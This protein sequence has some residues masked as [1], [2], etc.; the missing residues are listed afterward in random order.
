MSMKKQC[1]LI[2][3]IGEEGSPTRILADNVRNFL[4]FEI[5]NGLG[6]TCVRADD[7]NKVGM[8]TSDII[9][10]IINSDLVIALLEEENANVYY[11]L[12]LRHAT[13]KICVSIISRE[14]L[15]TG[16]LPFDIGQERA[17]KFPLNEMKQYAVGIEIESK[18]LAKFRMELV[19]AIKDYDESKYEF[20]NPVTSALHKVILPGDLTME[21]VLDMIGSNFDDMKSEM[22]MRLELLESDIGK[23]INGLDDVVKNWMPED[24][25][26]AVRDMYQNGSATYI[27]GENEAF[28]KLTEMTKTARRSLRTSRFA[29]QAIATSH[30]D[31]FEAVCRFGKMKNVVCKRIMC[32]N[33]LNKESDILKT[34][35]DT[36]GGSMELYLTD[37]DNNFELVVIDDTCAF[38]HFYDDTRRIKST[39]FIR[40]QRVVQEFEKI[41]DRF[42]EPEMDQL[43][44]K[45]DC[46]KFSTPAEVIEVIPKIVEKFNIKE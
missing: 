8:I 38:L 13:S 32:M 23:K 28:E 10:N 12:A 7:I 5:L 29:P 30:S 31:F 19:H 46:S 43:L 2:S 17:F 20:Y 26:S 40:G 3:P 36:A 6:Y 41:Y 34:V 33:E 42:L 18:E 27:S 39:L 15:N 11:E 9:A 45:I 44:E 14:Q 22:N 35:L 24:L 25:K 21:S 16:R 37:R 1:F 4:K